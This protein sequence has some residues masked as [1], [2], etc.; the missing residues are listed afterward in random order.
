MT[1]FKFRIAVHIEVGNGSS[2]LFGT[3][4]WINGH[5]VGHLRPAYLPR[6]LATRLCRRT[7]H[8]ALI[9]RVWAS[10]II[11][12]RVLWP[13]QRLNFSSG[14]LCMRDA[15]WQAEG[16][17]RDSKTTTCALC[18][19]KLRVVC[20]FTIGWLLPCLCRSQLLLS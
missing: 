10:D 14:W 20:V 13:H 3:D 7:I 5:S 18:A 12:A 19:I 8:S 17:N 16:R 11:G 9:N 6:C 1:Y 15:G 2:T 4:R